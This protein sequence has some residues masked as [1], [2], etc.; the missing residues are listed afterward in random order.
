LWVSNGVKGALPDYKTAIAG[1]VAGSVGKTMT[2][3][4][5]RMT[6]LYQVKPE[7]SKFSLPAAYSHVLKNEG[8]LAFWKGNFT[9]V[10]HR[11]PYSAINFTVYDNMRRM[12]CKEEK[13]ET[14]AIRLL[15]G[16]T[17]G[18][19]ACC[20]CYPLEIARTRLAAYTGTGSVS[21]VGLIRQVVVEEGLFRGLFR[22]LGMS[23]AVAVPNI[24]LSFTV[25]GSIKSYFMTSGGVIPNEH[26]ADPKTG[27]FTLVGGLLSGS[28][29][30][31]LSSL[32]TFP[33]D[34]IR[35]RLQ[36][37]RE[38]VKDGILK[39]LGSIV[40]HNGSVLGLYK[41]IAPELLRVMPM[42]GITFGTYE[43]VMNLLDEATGLSSDR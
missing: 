7:L 36:S 31:V 27:K 22:G 40:R 11:F 18:A 4:L 8:I 6:I 15:C 12:M 13:D 17:S 38:A 2:A 32:L 9:S 28:T 33:A 26:L 10:I 43:L 23:V 3:P 30:A 37:S 35:K 34:T 39:E 25:Y 19:T 42:A 24:A 16:A 20:S 14:V 1:G 21:L 41:G 29:S 5:S